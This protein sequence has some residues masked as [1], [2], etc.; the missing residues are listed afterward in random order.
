MRMKR[1]PGAASTG[2]RTGIADGPNLIEPAPAAQV[3]Q[4]YL[5]RLRS[6]R[7]GEDVGRLRAI[8]KVLLR[9]YGL[10]CLSIELEARR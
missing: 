4:I 9:G 7:G 2:A 10:K 1:H 8:L 3:P 6:L 5:L